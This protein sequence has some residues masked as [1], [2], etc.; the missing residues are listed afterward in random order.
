MNRMY[1]VL[2]Q[3]G[4]E[5]LTITSSMDILYARSV[6]DANLLR[7]PDDRLKLVEER[8]VQTVMVDNFTPRQPC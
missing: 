5:W 6:Y 8:T 4:D 3:H 7:R 1:K 2:V